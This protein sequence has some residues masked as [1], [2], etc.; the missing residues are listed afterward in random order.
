[1][2]LKTTVRKREVKLFIWKL[3]CHRQFKDHTTCIGKSCDAKEF[4]KYLQDEFDALVDLGATFK[5]ESGAESIRMHYGSAA[6]SALTMAGVT[7]LN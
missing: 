7:F 4:V 6:A 3:P 5:V 2:V 1:M